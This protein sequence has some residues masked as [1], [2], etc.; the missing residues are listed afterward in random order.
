MK[1]ALNRIPTDLPELVVSDQWPQDES[2][3]SVAGDPRAHEKHKAE[4]QAIAA[5]EV[6]QYRGGLPVL[7]TNL[8]RGLTNLRPHTTTLNALPGL[9]LRDL[10]RGPEFVLGLAWVLS[11]MRQF[12]P[13]TPESTAIAIEAA[14]L[15]GYAMPSL[16]AC[17]KK[18]LVPDAPLNKIALGRGKADLAQD[19]LDLYD[20]FGTHA[21]VLENNTC[22]DADDVRKL[23]AYGER[24][25]L[26]HTPAA[27]KKTPVNEELRGLAD[28]R[29]RFWTLIV[30]V[31][32]KMRLAGFHVWGESFDDHVPL[33]LSRPAPKKPSKEL[34]QE[35]K[36]VLTP[37]EAAKVAQEAAK[38][39]QE[40]AKAA[41]EAVEA[42]KKPASEGGA[43]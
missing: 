19:L 37:A 9:A 30:K 26:I 33:L 34:E 38:T 25:T 43:A 32:A 5:S 14:H 8:N 35:A 31:H 17:A 2:E 6:Q 36:K 29:D 11:Q 42:V 41:K 15:K 27:M 21:S 12:M 16:F 28:M 22:L 39:A 10:E 3:E 23:R 7:V 40:A 4:A 24:L 13:G 1:E 20:F 18:G